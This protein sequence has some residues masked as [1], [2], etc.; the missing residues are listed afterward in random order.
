VSENID[1]PKVAPI[2]RAELIGPI[3][4]D[5]RTLRGMT[6]AEVAHLL[7]VSR[8]SVVALEQG[9]TTKAVTTVIDAFALFGYQL[10]PVAEA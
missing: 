4:G 1:I 9:K 6:Q 5:L 7:G 3:L 10:Q 2:S 8:Q